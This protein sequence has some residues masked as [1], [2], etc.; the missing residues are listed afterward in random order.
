ML[1]FARRAC[2]PGLLRCSP[3]RAGTVPRS[4]LLPSLAPSKEYRHLP[5]Q[6]YASTNRS[7]NVTLLKEAVLE[8]HETTEPNGRPLSLFRPLLFTVTISIGSYLGAAYLTDQSDRQFCQ[9]TGKQDGIFADLV[10]LREQ[11]AMIK[12]NKAL[13]WLR[14]TE[15]PDFFEKAFLATMGKWL[16]MSDGERATIGLICV[17][18]LVFLAWQ[19]PSQKVQWFMR[20]AFLHSPLSGRSY[21]LLTSIFSHQV[22]SIHALTLARKRTVAGLD[23]CQLILIT[24]S[25]TAIALLR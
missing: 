9:E 11:L 25:W 1:L 19:M 17:N 20:R 24:W 23:N 6:Q 7:H 18:T 4:V 14:Q 16:G 21:T 8:P 3:P 2:T 10:I 5:S 13:S 22:S 15:M 12:T